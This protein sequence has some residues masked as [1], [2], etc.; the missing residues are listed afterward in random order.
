[1]YQPAHFSIDDQDTLHRIIREHP[2][3]LL[4][5]TGAAGLVANPIPFI[6]VKKAADVYLR[7]HV[8]R[9]NPQWKMVADGAEVLIVFQGEGAYIT[10][11]WYATKQDSGKVVPTWNYIIVQARGVAVVD[12]SPEWL[13]AQIDELTKQHESKRADAWAVSDAPEPYIAAQMRGIVGIEVR[14]TELAGKFKLSQNRND[15]DRRG[16]IAGLSQG[17]PDAASVGLEMRDLEARRTS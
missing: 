1:M 4:I 17:G 10:P 2:L 11:S 14:V 3:G 12:Q 5:S 9:A 13:R 8:A 15:A 16:V 6:L 7:C